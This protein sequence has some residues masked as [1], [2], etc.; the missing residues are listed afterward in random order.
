MDLNHKHIC[1]IIGTIYFHVPKLN[2]TR[3]F[4]PKRTIAVQLNE[5]GTFDHLHQRSSIHA[6]DVASCHILDS[7]ILPDLLHNLVGLNIFE[8]ILNI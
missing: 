6:M 1:K 2:A 8:D 7:H 4:R 3:W 5:F